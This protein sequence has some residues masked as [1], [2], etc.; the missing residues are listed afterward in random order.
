[1]YR[2]E[3]YKDLRCSDLLAD[4]FYE[5]SRDQG[6]DYIRTISSVSGGSTDQG[7][8][9]YE[10][11][12]LHPGFFID[13]EN[14]TIGPH[15]PSFNK[16]AGTRSGF[17]DSLKYAKRTPRQ[18]RDPQLNLLEHEVAG[19]RRFHDSGDVR[20]HTGMVRRLEE[21]ETLRRRQE[22]LQGLL[23]S[24]RSSNHNA[25]QFEIIPQPEQ[26][27]PEATYADNIIASLG[28]IDSALAA[29]S[30]SILGGAVR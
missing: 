19:F 5:H 21:N 20:R 4:K 22:H 9:S 10:L 16:S 17:E 15:H 13:V 18:P 11:P 1:M 28:N 27:D 3:S 25:L 29:T 7:N 12:S 26:R 23:C 2:L 30:S 24:W 6:L 14:L 8:V